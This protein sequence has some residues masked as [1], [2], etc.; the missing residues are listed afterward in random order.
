MNYKMISR[1]TGYIIRTEAA[2]LLLP[3][4]VS[5]IYRESLSAVAYIAT[6][7]GAFLLSLILTAFAKTE[8]K[9]IYAKEGFAIV[10]ITWIVLSAIGAVPFVI[11][12]EIPRYYDAFFE[13]VSGFTTTGASI[14]NDV[15]VLS[16]ASLLW[17]SFTHWVGGMGFIVF[18]I[19]IFP[20]ISDRTIHIMRAEVPGPSVGKLVP[21]IKD[22]AKILY[23]IYIALTILEAFFLY[24]G[25]MNLFESICHAIATAGTG[26]FGLKPDGIASYSPYT[27]W[28]ITVFML[29]FGINFNIYYLILIKRAKNI[30]K[31]EELWVY[32]SVI[33]VAT[34]AIC[35]NV[36]GMYET[37]SQTIRHA[38]FQVSS[39]ITT[40]GYATTDFNLWP[41]F[42][43]AILLLLMISGGCA[44]STAGG[45]KVSRI[46]ILFKTAKREL[47]QLIHPKAVSS[48]HSEGKPLD[49]RTVSGVGA[50]LAAY[51]MCIAALFLVLS[52]E[53]FDLETNISVAFSAFN[54]IGPA[55]G[56]AGPMASYAAYS[57]FSKIVISFAMLL[58][59]LE[60]FPLLIAL[61]PSTWSRKK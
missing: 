20:N 5:L 46:I 55:F 44:G 8:N 38:A 28:V 29:I 35:F 25:E 58:G 12:G 41:G 22:T 16:H 51:C 7:A 37:L 56:A 6:A 61:S 24:F 32:L 57:P 47:K 15:T 42:S 48:V 23:L 19:A 4:I 11:T 2:L 27:Q 18:V 33:V 49:A 21:R 40:T 60:I 14:L 30:L 10:A 54:N 13:T 52:F 43:K 34:A 3:F 1:L 39:I 59:R 45:I 36:R 50:Y 17:R 31:S 53:P 9:V 26:G